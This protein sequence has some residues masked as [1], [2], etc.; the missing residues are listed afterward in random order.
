MRVVIRCQTVSRA[1]RLRFRAGA[2]RDRQRV[3]VER[4]RSAGV[5]SE[6]LRLPFDPIQ[7][8]LRAVA[9]ER[10]QRR[11]RDPTQT[12]V[13]Q[14]RDA[15]TF[16]IED[17]DLRDQRVIDRLIAARGHVTPQ[18]AGSRWPHAKAANLHRQIHTLALGDLVVAIHRTGGCL[19]TGIEH[20]RVNQVVR[21]IGGHEIASGNPPERFARRTLHRRQVVK[22]ITESNAATP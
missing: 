11:A 17:A 15:T 1:Q 4:W 5:F 13:A 12:Q 21:P 20:R 9:D 16:P 10:T 8:V 22:V 7:P 6:R 19:Q 3:D 14:L 2:F 18:F